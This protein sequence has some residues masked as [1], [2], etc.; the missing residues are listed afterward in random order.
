MNKLIGGVAAGVF[1]TFATAQAG[2]IT[3]TVNQ[4]VKLNM[5]DSH[6]YTHNINDDGFVLGSAISGTLE[7]D[8]AD[9]RD[10]WFSLFE[11]IL[12]Q[13]EDFDFDTGTIQFGTAD[14]GSNLE[15][16]ALGALNADGYLDVTVK[17][18]SGDFYVGKSVLSVV[19]EAVPEPGT[20]A[21]LG[22]GLAG[23]GAAR[24]RKA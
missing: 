16:E 4:A 14:F 13:I 18:L 24:R 19:T 17:S 5:W 23:L 3:D 8:V 9:D 22:L 6:S 7:I 21:L 1:M 10:G 12:F 2:M 20:L 11:T 15:A